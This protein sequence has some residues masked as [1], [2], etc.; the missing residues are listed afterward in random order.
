MKKLSLIV[1]PRIPEPARR[2]EHL[3]QRLL[4]SGRPIAIKAIHEGL[5]QVDRRT[6]TR[7]QLIVEIG[8]EVTAEPPQPV[9]SIKREAS[10]SEPVQFVYED[11]HLVVIRKPAGL[12]TVPTPHRERHTVISQVTQQL[13]RRDQ[14]AEAYCVHR[15]DRG[16]SGLLV[17]VKS[18]E[19]AELM[20]NQF[21]ERKP[22]RRYVA[23]A[24]GSV[25]QLQGTI[26][27]YLATDA[28]LNQHSTDESS[29][30]L[31]ITHFRVLRR[32]PELTQVEV[33]LE[34]GRRNQIRV[35]FAEMGHPVLGDERYGKLTGMHRLWPFKRIAL[36]AESLGFTHP[37][38]GRELEFNAGLPREFLQLLNRLG[39][40]EIP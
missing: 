20:R 36:H 16:V 22:K 4:Q 12:L 28:A 21:A 38:T 29:G 39:P 40:P 11:E 3:V 9:V 2:L 7:P 31:A 30:K 19:V 6:A 24:R 17:F 13:R 37:V 10:R 5:V 23:F 8:S 32:W 26:Q 1:D 34:T 33:H 35:H 18:L 27:S 14:S 15:L 25:S